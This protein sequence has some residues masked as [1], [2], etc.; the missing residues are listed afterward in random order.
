MSTV[1]TID[2]Q[3][4]DNA[5]LD[6]IDTACRDHG[7]FLLIGHG[8]DPLMADMW[9]QAAAFFAAASATKGAVMRT[10]TNPLGYFDRELTKRKRDQKETFDFRPTDWM[11]GEK[12]MPWPTGMPTFEATLRRYFTANTVL[13][14]SVTRL[15]CQAMGTSPN[16]LDEAFGPHHTSMARIN[17]YPV[18]DPVPTEERINVNPL[19]HRP[20]RD[21]PF[22]SR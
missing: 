12:A 8:L 7:F 16:S 3:N 11:T 5:A 18:D 22:V 6:T 4:I 20:R 14:A 1:P 17:H 2:I 13:A 21:H 19:P 10:A 15:V 9:Q